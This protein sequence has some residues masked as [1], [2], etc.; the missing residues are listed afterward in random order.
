MGSLASFFTSESLN[1][2]ICKMEILNGGFTGTFSGSILMLHV[3]H[4]KYVHGKGSVSGD[5]CR[6]SGLN[7][8]PYNSTID[9]VVIL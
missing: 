7:Y 2:V 3:K 9:I 4:M 1:F 6:F 8:L 5:S